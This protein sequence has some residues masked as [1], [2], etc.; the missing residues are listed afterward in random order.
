MRVMNQRLV[1]TKAHRAGNNVKRK[2][3]QR[4]EKGGK[5]E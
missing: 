3:H 1:G 2:I 4:K 5:K